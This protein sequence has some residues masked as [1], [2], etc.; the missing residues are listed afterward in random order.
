MEKCTM[1]AGLILVLHTAGCAEPADRTG[2]MVEDSAG[3]T[4]VT[5]GPATL[6]SAAAWALSAEPVVEIGGGADPAHPLHQVTAVVPLTGGRVAVGTNRPPGASLFGPDGRLAALLGSPG[7][8]PG[9]FGTL[10]SMVPLSPDSLALWD[11]TR[12]RLS[13]FTLDGRLAREVDL[14]G[15]ALP[16]PLAAGSTSEL[17][18]W[19]HVLSVA[20]GELALFQ[21]GV[22]GDGGSGVRRVPAPSYLISA[23]GE[24]LA[25]LGPFPGDQ[26]Y[27]FGPAGG[28]PFIFPFGAETH[29]VAAD[30]AIVVG[31]GSVSELRRYGPDGSLETIVRWAHDPRPVE[32]PFLDDWTDFVDAWLEPMSP[33]EQDMFRGMFD[34]IP[35]PERFP[36]YDELI[37]GDS[38]RVWVGA[39]AGEHSVVYPPRN[40]PVPAREWLVFDREGVLVARVETPRGFVPRAVTGD[41]VWGVHTDDLEVES[42]RAYTIARE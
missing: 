28:G 29:A 6:E 39:Y 7:R 31:T 2:G 21:V 26:T 13:V 27:D 8:G 35:P 11:D 23:A 34:G 32:G 36:A 3:V 19:T 17:A 1:V 5:S 30:G 10:A 24:E 33:G 14:S 20:K 41:R 18:A 16:T 15:L 9:E 22:W 38:G 42:V 37:A 12:R 4:I 40:A 25:V